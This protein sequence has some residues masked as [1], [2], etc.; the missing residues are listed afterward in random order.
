MMSSLFE[1]V[2]CVYSNVSLMT[3]DVHVTGLA[4]DWLMLVPAMVAVPVPKNMLLLLERASTNIE[5]TRPEGTVTVPAAP[6]GPA[7]VLTVSTVFAAVVL[8]KPDQCVDA[9]LAPLV[10]GI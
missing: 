8:T 9:E 1:L 2:L 3:S 6:P 10:F 7:R 4:V 5:P